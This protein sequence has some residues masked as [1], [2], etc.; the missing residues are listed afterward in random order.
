VSVTSAATSPEAGAARGGH[1]GRQNGPLPRPSGRCWSRMVST[2]PGLDII[3]EHLTEINVTSPTCVRELDR[4][5]GIN[6]IS[7]LFD[8]ID[9]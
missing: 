6:I 8:V 1:W 2:S 7:D 9:P 4:E 3:G 5:F